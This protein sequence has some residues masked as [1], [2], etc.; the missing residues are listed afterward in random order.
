M[1][2]IYTADQ[3]LRKGLHL[4]GY[5]DYMQ[6][7]VKR[8]ANVDR[9]KSAFG[10]KPIVCA[11]IFNDL[12]TTAVVAARIAGRE[13]DVECFLMGI[14][15]LNV[16]PLEDNKSGTFK[17]CVPTSRKWCWLY[18]SKIQALKAEK[19]STVS[20]LPLRSS[21]LLQPTFLLYLKDQMARR[22]GPYTC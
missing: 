7:N 4:V 17:C 22:M 2:F 1:V 16:Y 13:V 6:G 14:Y 21:L 12:Q 10:S 3:I 9:F 18:S 15:F 5:D 20:F 8:E 11:E 19:V